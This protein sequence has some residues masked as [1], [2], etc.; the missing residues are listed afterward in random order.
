MIEVLVAFI[1]LT[2]MTTVIFLLV[3][4]TDRVNIESKRIHFA[5]TLINPYIA[6]YQNTEVRKS[7]VSIYLSDVQTVDLVKEYRNTGGIVPSTLVDTKVVCENRPEEVAGYMVFDI[8]CEVNGK[9]INKGK[10][11]VIKKYID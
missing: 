4:E 7:D 8:R 6:Y 5:E 9:E 2:V 10:S 3:R 11:Y 1:L